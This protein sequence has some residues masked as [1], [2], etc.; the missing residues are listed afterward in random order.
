M[1]RRD[2]KPHLARRGRRPRFVLAAAALVAGAIA[3]SPAP[4][5][6]A[7]ASLLEPEMLVPAEAI[8]AEVDARYRQ[9]PRR[10][11]TVTEATTT[12]VLDSLVL[13]TD[14]VEPRVVSAANGIYFALCTIGAKCPYPRRT[15]R[16]PATAVLPRMAALELASL[17]FLNTSAGVVV[18]ALPTAEPVWVVFER[19]DFLSAAD[20]RLVLA[21][22]AP[23]RAAIDTPRRELVDRLTRPR[24]FSPI[25]TLPPSR[26]IFAVGLSSP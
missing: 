9:L 15:P 17:T 10:K 3:V 14:G 23:L 21:Q 5:A 25:P 6:E 22:L 20:P 8:R 1:F 24:L 7:V 18:V 26:T 2:A 11:L 12:S 19:D 16:W 13:L 4:G